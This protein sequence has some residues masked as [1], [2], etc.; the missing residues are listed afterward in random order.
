MSPTF[1]RQ[2]LVQPLNSHFFV[3]NMF[4]HIEEANDV[5]GLVEFLRNRT[6]LN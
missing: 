3:L 2:A 1:W 5:I 6:K 4:E